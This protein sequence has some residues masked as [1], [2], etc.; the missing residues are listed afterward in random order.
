MRVLLVV[1]ETIGTPTEGV[2]HR[3]TEIPSHN[4]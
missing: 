1:P 3:F 4:R 2:T